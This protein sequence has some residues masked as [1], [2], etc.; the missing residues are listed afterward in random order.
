MDAAQ[1]AAERRLSHIEH[2]VGLDRLL[3]ETSKVPL[4]LMRQDV[5]GLDALGE[6]VPPLLQG[7]QRH[8]AV[9]A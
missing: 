6:L 5:Q 3:P 4:P 8:V 9:E 7:L 2:L 1:Y